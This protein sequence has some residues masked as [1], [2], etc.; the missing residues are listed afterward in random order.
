MNRL[1]SSERIVAWATSA[2]FIFAFLSSTIFNRDPPKYEYPV[3]F[4]GTNDKLDHFRKH[5]PSDLELACF[6]LRDGGVAAAYKPFQVG[7]LRELWQRR[8]ASAAPAFKDF[9]CNGVITFKDGDLMFGRELTPLL[10]QQISQISLLDHGRFAPNSLLRSELREKLAALAGVPIVSVTGKTPEADGCVMPRALGDCY[11]ATH[12]AALKAFARNASAPADSWAL[13]LDEGLV[14]GSLVRGPDDL[15]VVL[16]A[17]L[18]AAQRLGSGLVHLGLCGASP[19]ACPGVDASLPPEAAKVLTVRGHGSRLS[20]CE[21]RQ[22]QPPMALP[23]AHAAYAV[24]KDVAAVLPGL[25]SS[26]AA[27]Q[28]ASPELAPS[29]LVSSFGEALDVLAKYGS[30]PNGGMALVAG[31]NLRSPRARDQV[32]R[33]VASFLW[34]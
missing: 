34:A 13:V 18:S 29:S 28:R 2:F 10:P 3:G 4:E 15:S 9:A 19:A 8:F 25:V 32:M 33:V 14:L 17:S 22:Q 20:V 30:L 26:L 31:A 23:C 16:G 21:H 6:R 12:L 5:L 24:R 1:P 11:A 27:S 7:A